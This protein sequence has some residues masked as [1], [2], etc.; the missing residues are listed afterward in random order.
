MSST[1]FGSCKL[2]PPGHFSS[3]YGATTSSACTATV[4][5][6][7][8]HVEAFWFAKDRIHELMEAHPVLEHNLWKMAGGRIAADLLSLLYPYSRW[9]R[10]KLST[11]LST[12]TLVAPTPPVAPAMAIAVH[13]RARPSP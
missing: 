7:T 13:P 5:A 6:A 8:S 11:W 9:K 10:T 3:V 1:T 2:C 4:R 12:A